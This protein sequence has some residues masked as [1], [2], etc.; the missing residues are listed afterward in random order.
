MQAEAR[1]SKRAALA[2]V[3]CVALATAAAVSMSIMQYSKAA[4]SSTTS[5]TANSWTTGSVTISDDD[6]GTAMFNATGLTGGSSVQ[7]CIKVTYTG[8]VT[9][10]VS[11][12]IY[13]TSSGSLGPYLN[14]TIDQ[15][16][17]GTFASCAGFS[18]GGTIYSGT[19]SNFA[20]TYT[21]FGNGLA[22]WNPVST[23][24]NR[25]YRFTVTV[26]NNNAAQGLTASADYTWEAQG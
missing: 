3:M 16:T 22:A 17:G 11:I 1:I 15:G 13:G 4:F 2:I 24:D 19:V 12:A 25:V 5:N 18:S 6:S 9:A 26:Q 10:G 7:H 8:S 21:N 23:P 20:S 14:L